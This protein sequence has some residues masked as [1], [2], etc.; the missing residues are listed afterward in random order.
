IDPSSNLGTLLPVRIQYPTDEFKQD[1][2]PVPLVARWQWDAQ[3][4]QY[5]IGIKCG[6]AWCEVGAKGPVPAPS[7]TSAAGASHDE[8]IVRTF[9]GWY[10]EQP[11]AAA[12]N[13]GAM[14]T[15]TGTVFPAPGPERF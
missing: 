4:N 10:D 15:I 1:E 13:R 8:S 2:D 7:Y 9:K 12:G 11:L 14:L 3:E 5:Y 6:R